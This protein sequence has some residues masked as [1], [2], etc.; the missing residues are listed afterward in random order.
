[1]KKQSSLALALI[2]SLFISAT[3][4]SQ[5]PGPQPATPQQQDDDEV[6]RITTNLVQV[7][8][9]VTKDGK[10]VADLLPE[11]FE[12]YE[13][14]RPQKITNFSYVSTESGTA[15]PVAVTPVDKTAPPVPPVRLRPEQVRRTIAL[16]VDDLGLSFESTAF[17]RQALKKFVDKQLQPGDLVAIVRTAGGMGAL[18]QFTSDK[19]Q[20]YAAI[21]RVKWNPQGRG[22]ISAF[23]PIEADPLAQVRDQIPS[24]DSDDERDRPAGDDIEQFREE[25]FSVGTLGALNYVIRGMKELP[26]RKS[27][28]LMSDGIKIFN[29]DDPSRS[30][31]VLEAL[32]RLTDLANRASV[33]V[34]TMDA[35][36]LP[37]FGLSAADSTSGLSAEQLETR[38]A[39]RSFDFFESQSGLDYIARQT[40]GIPIRNNND[41]AAG[42]QRVLDDQ[43]GYYLIGYR[44]D[45]STFEATM[46]RRK[47]HKISIKVKRP[48]M[49]VRSR[50]GFYGITD[51]EA[52]PQRGTRAQQLIGALT[53]PFASGGIK[54]RLTTLFGNDQKAGSF[55]RSLLHIDTR[56]LTFTDEPEGWHKA[57]FDVL[58]VTFGDNGTVVDELSRTHTVRMRG[59]TYKKALEDGLVYIVT[60]P[61]KKPGAYQ[62]RAALRDATN[63]RVGSASQFIE[64]PNI[65]KNRLT[66][67]GLVVSGTDP[68]ARP[69]AGAKE[70]ASDSLTPGAPKTAEGD[71]GE[72]DPKAGPAV[73][74]FRRGM[75]MQ[76]GYAIYNAQADKSTA[77]PQV[78]T[79]IRLFRDGKQIFAGR[80]QP[81]D[82]SNQPDPKRLVAGGALQLGTEMAPGEYIL[83]VVVTDPLAKEKYRTATQWIDFEI[84]K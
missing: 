43:K 7:D 66:L 68:A 41:L 37:W 5:N 26:G 34:Y 28:L 74:N 18:Q 29:R 80:T 53:S 8:A 21:E 55:M 20:L 22:G 16:V 81:L 48:G 64:V 83:Q 40:G 49:N 13:D 51:E 63:E 56:G 82:V 84:V 58:A 33:V 24:Q 67:S 35:R 25:L 47:F 6:V 2:L 59:E 27:I 62:L 42:I 14:G 57:T 4:Q 39:N 71:G 76:Y 15:Q 3:G 79:Q 61:I 50:T 69:K 72:S 30:T 46:G 60:V 70:A 52:V 36:G 9:I 32:R 31:R 65:T 1:M 23:A 75:I 17:V 73:R 10:Q 77:R 54:L 12:I 44:P 45:E 11:D 19:Q 78:Q 38:L